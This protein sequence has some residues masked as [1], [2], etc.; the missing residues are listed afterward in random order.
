MSLS[1]A[2]HRPCAICERFTLFGITRWPQWISVFAPVQ[3]L[4]PPVR[5]GTRLVIVTVWK[6]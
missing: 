3:P 1:T 2:V 6:S 4:L 5:K